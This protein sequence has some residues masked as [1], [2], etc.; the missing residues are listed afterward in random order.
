MTTYTAEQKSKALS[1][2]VDTIFEAI[3]ASGNAG[4]P[5]GHLYASLMQIPNFQLHHLNMI[6]GVLEGKGKITRKNFLL[7]AA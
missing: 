2:L 7:K 6:L 1:M 4:I 5:E 3:Q